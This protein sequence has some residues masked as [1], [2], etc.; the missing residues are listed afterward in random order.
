MS[1]RYAVRGAQAMTAHG[2]LRAWSFARD[3]NGRPRP[4]PLQPQHAPAA[5]RLDPDGE[6]L[7][8]LRQLFHGHVQPGEI[9]LRVVVRAPLTGVLVHDE[10]PTARRGERPQGVLTGGDG[11]TPPPATHDGLP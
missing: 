4:F 2:A 10:L 3:W 7:H 11:R 9:V 5:L 8:G 1:V 6:L